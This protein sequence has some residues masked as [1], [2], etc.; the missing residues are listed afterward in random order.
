LKEV[1]D[2]RN[3]KTKLLLLLGIRC[4]KRETIAERIKDKK[5]ASED[6]RGEAKYSWRHSR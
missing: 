5:Y 6:D 2:K 3:A 4:I 1:N